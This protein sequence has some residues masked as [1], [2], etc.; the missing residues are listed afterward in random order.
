VI[1]SKHDY[2]NC[3][4]K[5]IHPT[6]ESRI[7]FWEVF[8]LSWEC[9]RDKRSSS[10]NNAEKNYFSGK[11]FQ[12]IRALMEI[13]YTYK[14]TRQLELLPKEVQKRIAKKMRFYTAQENPLKFAESLTDYREGEHRFRVGKYRLNFDVKDGIIYILKIKLRDK[15]YD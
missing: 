14:A 6:K 2:R 8:G 3:S 13:F 4:Q 15:A 11:A 5:R 12:E 9:A 10:G 7:P 1:I